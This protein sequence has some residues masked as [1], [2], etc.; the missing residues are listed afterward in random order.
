MIRAE[1]LPKDF[2]DLRLAVCG[3]GLQT[4]PANDPSCAQRLA[5]ALGAIGYT[6]IWVTGYKGYVNL[7]G[8]GFRVTNS[9]GNPVSK[10]TRAVVYDANGNDV[11]ANAI[12][13]GG[14]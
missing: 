2:R 5:R 6:K 8:N 1:K 14:I 4:N 3:S 9:N 10:A 13:D 11:S 7:D 12:P